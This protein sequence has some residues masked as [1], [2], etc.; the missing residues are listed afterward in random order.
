M[1]KAGDTGK[2][3]AS[4][5]G[6]QVMGMEN[7]Q[8]TV[9]QLRKPVQF[10]KGVGPRLAPLFNRLGLWTAGDVLFFFPRAYEDLTRITAVESIDGSG[11][12]C[13]CA[14]VQEVEL[15]TLDGGRSVLGVLL[16]DETGPIRAVWFNQ[17]FMREKLAVG[18]RVMLYGAP[19]KRGLCW[20]MSHPRLA[21][22]GAGEAPAGGEMLPIYP[23][24]D[25]LTQAKLRHVAR[26]VVA[27]CAD[28]IAE[29]FPEHFLAEH[30]LLTVSEAL[31]RIH[32][33]GGP[34]DVERARR[35][36]AYQEV[37]VLQ[38]ALSMRRWQLRNRATAPR[39]TATTKVD[40]R[41]R[42]LFP[43]QLTADQQLA[44]REI[45][46]D[47]GQRFPMNRLLQGEV[48][49]GKTVVAEYAMLLAVAHGYQSVLMAPTEVLAQQ[50]LHT[51]T[52][53][54]RQSRVRIEMLTGSVTGSQRRR[55]HELVREGG[56]DL[57][58]GTH[59]LLHEHLE[60]ARLGLVVID[61]QHKFG[62]QQRATLKVAGGDPHYLIMTATPIPRTVT[63]SLFGDLEVSTLRQS[64]P[65]RQNVHTY[66]GSEQERE[67]WWKFFR[68]KLR[69]GRQ[70]YVI[71]PRVEEGESATLASVE[72]KYEQ[73]TNG[74]LEAFR[75]DLIHGRMSPAEKN[76]V[77]EAFRRGETQVLVATSVIEVGVDVPNATLMTIEN[78]ERFGLAQLHQLRGRVRRGQFP[79]YVCVFAT[80]GN[81]AAQQRLQAFVQS[82]DGFHLAELDFSLRGP[83]N[84]FGTRQHGL[85]P[86]RVADLQRDQKILEEARDDAQKLFFAN[87]HEPALFEPRY[88][89]LKQ[90]VL[91]RYGEMLNLADVG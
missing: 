54:L 29:V 53:D 38:L 17:P 75:V 88:D 39:L 57:V 11:Q 47:M 79:G 27:E 73:L 45:A 81:S 7:N 31:R 62:V 91:K 52:E 63:M 10:L 28:T 58:V 33:P 12:V 26:H 51:L 70:A 66:L 83:G 64:P 35:R 50:H 82:T 18:R 69:E 25:G 24:T 34:R 1:C 74:P 32:R 5:R 15:R 87:P 49:S 72:E 44:I 36:F 6:Y 42:R 60:F 14:T 56:V 8:D 46:T 61:E 77:M 76:N 68:D 40:A 21:A 90:Q 37:L 2:G 4:A 71:A 9:A 59:A 84:L 80:P 86:F 3:G 65:G 23:S 16:R 41:I 55:L 22:L 30:E 48:G 89:N 20:Q 67:Q 85:P 19:K 13:V 78:G 43:F